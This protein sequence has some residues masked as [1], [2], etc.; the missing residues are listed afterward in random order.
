MVSINP[1]L[2]G[3]KVCTQ[4]NELLPMERFSRRASARDGRQF[5]CKTCFTRIRRAH[6]L[7][8]K[9]KYYAQARKWSAVNPDKVRAS[10]KK[11][12][13][14]N[15]KK[16]EERRKSYRLKSYDAHRKEILQKQRQRRNEL[17]DCYIRQLIIQR[18]DLKAS[19][20]CP[21]LVNATR[22]Y[23]RVKRLIKEKA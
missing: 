11:Y 23:I 10:K 5:A 21:E 3:M 19:A 12:L 20:V 8:H 4:C 17:A 2:M 7:K 22:E 9:E 13:V 18:G 14:N 1:V 16:W 15:A 6:Y